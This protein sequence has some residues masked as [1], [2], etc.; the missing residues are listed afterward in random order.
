MIPR[1]SRSDRS[2]TLSYS[3]SQRIVNEN[4]PGRWRPASARTND[5]FL[6]RDI[7][8]TTESYTG[9]IQQ[10]KMATEGMG[11]IADHSNEHFSIADSMI[12]QTRKRLV[13]AAR[14]LADGA[15]A[16]VVDTPGV[17]SVRSGGVVLKQ[18]ADWLEE[19]NHLRNVPIESLVGSKD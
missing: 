8:R 11:P 6:D 17:Y 4:V 10:D 7:Q 5:F 16:S 3:V 12:I 19:T 9:F 15:P 18:G 13:E 1:C 2:V 14:A